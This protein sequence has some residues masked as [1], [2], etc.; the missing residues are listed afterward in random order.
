MPE[1]ATNTARAMRVYFCLEE[2]MLSNHDHLEECVFISMTN[3]EASLC[4]DAMEELIRRYGGELEQR[5]K[6][7]IID[8]MCCVN[9]E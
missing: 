4:Y 3:E 9:V 2:V 6:D 5:L 1:S 8:L 7:A